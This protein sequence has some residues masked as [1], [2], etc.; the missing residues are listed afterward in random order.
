MKKHTFISYSLYTTLAFSS[1]LV[2]CSKEKSEEQIANSWHEDAEMAEQEL[3][4]STTW[5]KNE[6]PEASAFSRVSL[7]EDVVSV[8]GVSSNV[9]ADYVADVSNSDLVNSGSSALSSVAFSQAPRFGPRAHNDGAMGAAAEKADI[10][11]WMNAKAG[12]TYS[13]TYTLNTTTNTLG[14]DI[15]TIQTIHGWDSNSGFQKNQNYTVEV[16]SVGSAY[17]TKVTTVEFEPFSNTDTI[18]SSRVNISETATGVLAKGVDQ[19]RF[20]YTV[21]ADPGAQPSPTI[22]EIDVFGAATMPQ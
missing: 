8:K 16:S 20:T 10:T 3:S 18:G 22:R 11:F 1:L 2:S 19:I 15:H 6:A 9:D 13:I 4:T 17:F 12:D 5:Q 21:Q 7:D 14:Y